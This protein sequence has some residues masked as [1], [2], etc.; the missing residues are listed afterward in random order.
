MK[1][2]KTVS[3]E[4]LGEEGVRLFAEFDPDREGARL[5]IVKGSEIATVELDTDETIRITE[6]VQN[7]VDDGGRGRNAVH[8]DGSD[9]VSFSIYG[10][11]M[12]EPYRTGISL[13]LRSPD[14][15]A[16]VFLEM[17][18]V[19]SFSTFLNAGVLPRSAPSAR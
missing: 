3:K 16:G 19:R 9:E 8:L 10:D 13:W 17:Y 6:A 18:E 7:C 12:G 5:S 2:I 15:H 11:N 4:F 1:I 14:T